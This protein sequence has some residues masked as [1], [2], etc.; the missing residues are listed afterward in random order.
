MG[1]DRNTPHN[2]LPLLPPECEIDSKAVLKKAIS[3][4]RALA[5]LRMAAKQLPNEAVFYNNLYLLEAK[6]SSE[7]ENIITTNDQLFRALAIED[8]SVDP[9]TREVLHYLD[10]LWQGFNL[11]KTQRVI[12]TNT[13]IKIVNTIKENDRGIREIPGVKIANEKTKEIIYT[14]PEGGD[15]IQ[16]KLRNLEEYINTDDGVDALIKMAVIHYQFE[17][18]HP[19]H[20][21]N[22]R[23]GRILNVLF[24]VFAGLL[25][26]P[27]L[28]LSQYI[29]DSKDD[30]YVGLREV[31]EQQ[32][33]EEWITYMLDGVEQS[34]LA[35]TNKIQKIVELMDKTK[36][37]IKDKAPT[38]YS[39]DLL[40]ILFSMP[41]TRINDLI[42]A[43]LGTRITAT[44]YLNE[45]EAIGILESIKV[46]RNK[47]F[48]NKRFYS[49]LE[50]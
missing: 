7:I 17:A 13:L 26:H 38:T 50:N 25:D 47:L 35:M 43:G 3:A 30:Y 8:K 48:V 49:L 28:F 2:S 40:E 11:L 18:I 12:T 27:M 6:E 36:G 46:G 20:D 21:G 23:T 10:A 1:F 32:K 16:E 37:E 33:W 42:E 14:P 39:K 29:L 31:T 19:F 45:L 5:G 34:S 24:L 41:Y 44:K 15:V 22:G 9:N 4:N